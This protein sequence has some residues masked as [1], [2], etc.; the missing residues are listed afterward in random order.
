MLPFLPIDMTGV[1]PY[2]AFPFGLPG[3]VL[4]IVGCIGRRRG[5]PLAVVGAI[6]S[7]VGLVLGGI[8]L[9]LTLANKIS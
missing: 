9:V 5:K 4:A 8:M 1:R 6:L 7:V 2:I 3:I